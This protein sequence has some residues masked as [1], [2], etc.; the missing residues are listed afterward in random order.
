[1]CIM[2]TWLVWSPS[3]PGSILS[4]AFAGRCCGQGAGLVGKS[5][6]LSPLELSTLLLAQTTTPA[7]PG[8]EN[9]LRHRAS[10]GRLAQAQISRLRSGHPKLPEQTPEGY[11]GIVSPREVLP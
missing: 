2:G 3:L 8:P 4:S 6:Q 11:W 1:M 10:E 5:E 7:A 9:K